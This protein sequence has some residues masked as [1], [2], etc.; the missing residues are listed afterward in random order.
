M[1]LGIQQTLWILRASWCASVSNHI[2]SRTDTF[3]PSF[4]MIIDRFADAAAHA[5]TEIISILRIVLAERPLA[6]FACPQFRLITT[7]Q[8]NGLTNAAT[9]T[10]NLIP[11]ILHYSGQEPYTKFEIC[12]VFSKLLGITIPHI[13]PDDNEPTGAA[14]ISRPRDCRLYTRETEDLMKEAGGLGVSGFEEWWTEHL[15]VS[16]VQS[17]TMTC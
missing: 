16:K 8:I 5:A 2:L 4:L 9:I 3:V 14:A 17:S 11:P 12:L 7:V 15:G 1:P 6:R 10:P 13:T